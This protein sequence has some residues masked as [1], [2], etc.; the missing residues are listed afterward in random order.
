MSTVTT[1]AAAKASEPEAPKKRS[2]RSRAENRLGQRLV[3]PAVIVMLA[4]TAWPMIQALYLSLFRYRL[5]SPDDKEFVG[6]SNYGTV[7]TDGLFWQDTWNTVLIMVVTVGGRAGDR[8]RVRDGDAPHRV[9][10]R[11]RSGRRS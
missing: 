11:R 1:T 8:L 3:A 2:D 7:L 4:V 5:T 9:R 6:L 10:P